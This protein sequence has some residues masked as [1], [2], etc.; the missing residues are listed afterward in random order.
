MADE[1]KVVD[2]RET[3]RP[4]A[5]H[6]PRERLGT[7]VTRYRNAAGKT[8]EDVAEHL[9]VTEFVLSEVERFGL[10][11]S[12]GQLQS[13]AAYLKIRYEPLLDAARDWHRA[14]WEESGKKG[15]V[16]L[17]GMTTET[18]SLRQ[19]EHELELELIKAADELVFASNVMREASIRAEQAALRA[20]EL[21]AAGGVEVPGV[22]PLDGPLEVE[23]SGPDHRLSKKLLRGRDFVL[24]YKGDGDESPCYFCSQS[25][26][27]AWSNS[28]S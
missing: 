3:S 1:I 22:E 8:P 19:T 16:Q 7:L 11:L 18:A 27:T 12:A 4:I 13:L 15:G 9:G 24:T 6:P 17:S 10:T 28:R 5:E 20:R 25:C 26:A 23:C 14:I 2:L 21:L